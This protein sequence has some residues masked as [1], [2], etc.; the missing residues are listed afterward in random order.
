MT[1][2]LAEI[3]QRRGALV[4]RARS[5]RVDIGELLDSQRELIHLVDAGVSWAK[6]LA[7]MRCFFVV[8]AL[9]FAITRPRRTLRWVMRTWQLS[10][11]ARKV[12]RLLAA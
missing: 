11:F 12:R 9:A 10:R 6:F 7:T 1:P 3:R 8:A 4:E 2:S 5:E